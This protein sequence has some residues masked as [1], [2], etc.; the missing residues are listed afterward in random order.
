M[1]KMIVGVRARSGEW[2]EG[3]GGKWRRGG[4]LS[5]SEKV[6]FSTMKA[7]GERGRGE[8][9]EEKTSCGGDDLL[10]LINYYV[11]Q[12]G[13]RFSEPGRVSGL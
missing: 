2:Q 9:I 1:G 6:P 11:E 8:S 4:L 12:G 7:S 13:G 5:S 3:G 10:S